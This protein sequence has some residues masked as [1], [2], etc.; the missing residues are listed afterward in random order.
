MKH[1]I[2]AT[3]GHVDHGKTALIKALTGID[4]DR[5]P[6]EKA[7]GITID[8]GFAHLQLGD[9]SLGTV[10][11]PG[12]EDFVRNMVAGVGSI[13]LALLVVAA[14]DGWMPQTEEH[15]QILE[16]LGVNRALIALTKCDLA[17][18]DDD[19]IRMRVEGTSFAGAPIVPVSV[20][21]GNGLEELKRQI[22]GV[23]ECV[24][25]PRDIGKPRLAVD[26]AFTLRGIGLVVTGTLSGGKLRRGDEIAVQPTGRV[27]RIRA[28]QSHGSDIAVAEPG[29]R[30]A[31]SIPGIEIGRGD[32]I[33][34]IAP[35]NSSEA[36]DVFVTRSLRLPANARSIKNGAIVRVHHGTATSPARIFFANGEPLGRGQSAVAELRFDAPVFAFAGDRFVLRDSSEQQTLAGA[37]VL[38]A[39]ASAR[40][41]RSH[42]QQQLLAARAEA[43]DDA[44]LF[45]RTQLRRDYALPRNLLLLQSRFSAGEIERAS[46]QAK[47]AN[48][49]VCDP[50]WWNAICARAAALIE[51]EHKAHPHHVG[52][53]LARLRE[54]LAN[55]LPS[56]EFFDLLIAELS[57]H[58]FVRSN[59]TIRHETHRPSLPVSLDRAGSRI[60]AS[61]ARNP[62]DPPSSKELAPDAAAL[63]ALRFLRDTNE[64]VEITSDLV[65]G[66][67]AVEQMRDKITELL[68]ANGGATVSELRQA[69]GSSRRVVVPL[70]EYFDRTGV[71]RRVGD[72]RVL[73]SAR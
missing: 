50:E 30:T 44:A 2:L 31:L 37:L 40:R 62:F 70:L 57:A 32:V 34:T 22:E 12:H 28:I 6:E 59:E 61:L 27:A 51:G 64:I 63:Q 46:A 71:T 7:R 11:V 23:C 66:R 58:G 54:A 49:F 4:T 33:T 47:I 41:F 8:L 1:F 69:L 56:A 68:R 60:R 72:K 43:P 29:M 13:D 42:A 73:A 19:A 53:D 15:L 20:R 25:P 9:V 17:S 67:L 48:E 18:P 3:A 5:L 35:Q 26:R 52:L 45:V 14:D 38:D 24:P 55:D 65:I 16:Y 36:T 39:A 10:D 21:T